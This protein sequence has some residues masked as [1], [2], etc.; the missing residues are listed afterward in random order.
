MRYK[1]NSLLPRKPAQIVKQAYRTYKFIYQWLKS[2]KLQPL[3][4][5]V[6]SNN[7]AKVTSR[8]QISQ[9]KRRSNNQSNC[10]S[11]C[12]LPLSIGILF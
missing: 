8:N 4:N 9:Q 2:T 6:E 12:G 11:C 7:I 3:R 5:S 1:A 10:V